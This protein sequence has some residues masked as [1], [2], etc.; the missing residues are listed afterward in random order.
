MG[1]AN[2]KEVPSAPAHLR[3]LGTYVQVGREAI[4]ACNPHLG[5]PPL[6]E[7]GAIAIS[8]ENALGTCL[9]PHETARGGS[10]FPQN[11]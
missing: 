2:D 5:T 3:E 11:L 6:L 7:S 9:T 8:C 4:S 10:G 1:D